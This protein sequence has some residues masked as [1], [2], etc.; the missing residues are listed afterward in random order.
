MIIGFQW[1]FDAELF[2]ISAQMLRQ[3]LEHIET[4]DE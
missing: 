1:K 2:F 3:L 4:D